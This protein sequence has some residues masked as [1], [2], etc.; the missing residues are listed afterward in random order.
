MQGLY[1]EKDAAPFCWCKQMAV[2]SAT[3]GCTKC[4]G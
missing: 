2:P 4:H 1:L 3:V